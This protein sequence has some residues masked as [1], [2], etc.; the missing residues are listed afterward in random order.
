MINFRKIFAVLCFLCC[1]LYCTSCSNELQYLD[2]YDTGSAAININENFSYTASDDVPLNYNIILGGDDIQYSNG[3]IFFHNVGRVP[4]IYMFPENKTLC[5]YNVKTNNLTTVCPDPLCLHNTKQCALFGMGSIKYIHNDKIIY[6]CRYMLR[7]ENG[8]GYDKWGGHVMYDMEKNKSYI[9]DEIDL[10]SYAERIIQLFVDNYSFY[11][12]NIYN[13]DIDDWVFS[14]CRWD[15]EKNEII[16]IG[17]EENVHNQDAEYPD[18]MACA[19]LFAINS[20]I[21]FTDSKTIYSTDVNYEN[22]IDHVTGSFLLDVYT[23]GEYIYYGVPVE[24][25]SYVQS[26]H[27][28]DFDGNNDIELGVV[29]EQRNVKLTSNYIYYKKYDE[30]EI[31]KADVRWYGS[32]T[33]TLNSSE[34]W[35]C[36]HDGTN[37]EL[38]YKFEGDM[39]NYRLISE[40]Y[41]GNYIYA[42]YIWYEDAD[43]DG[44]FEE[45]DQHHGFSENECKI[46]RIDITTGEIY[47]ID[48]TL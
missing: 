21:Y 22:K 39:A 24:K 4:N 23:D 14:V 5:K 16:V 28:M 42:S 44:I 35:R 10:E 13:E 32:D 19:F 17:G 45:G 15:M 38:I 33:V 8:E 46:M 1:F 27:R 9:R 20:R 30:I 12:D 43:N 3:Y 41:V 2:D 18:V 48:G 25:G 6:L 40:I 11:Y 36:N 47:I 7:F 29:S 26:L 31:G 34:I 37:H